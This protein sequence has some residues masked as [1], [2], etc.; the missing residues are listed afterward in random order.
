MSVDEKID[1]KEEFEKYINLKNPEIPNPRDSM[2]GFNR[3]DETEGR[4]S[5]VTT[6]MSQNLRFSTKISIFDQ[7]FV[8]LTKISIFD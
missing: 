8:L 5:S 6:K 4:V 2:A 7:N 1:S 3:N